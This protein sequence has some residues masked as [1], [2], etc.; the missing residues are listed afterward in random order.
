M[1]K[2]LSCPGCGHEFSAPPPDTMGGRIS[3]ARKEKW[4]D[5][6]DLAKALGL[7]QGQVSRIE[8]GRSLLNSDQIVI[9]A[10]CLGVTANY[11]LGVDDDQ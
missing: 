11:L 8:S 6:K 2:L 9:V 5:Q 3:Y 4:M 7:S 1:S 10:K